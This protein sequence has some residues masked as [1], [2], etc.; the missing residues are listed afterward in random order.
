MGLFKYIND[1]RSEMKHVAWPTHRQTAVFTILVIVLSLITAMYL[2]FFDFLFTR[3]LQSV[4]GLET[5]QTATTTDSGNELNLP[6]G[7][8]FSAQAVDENGVPVDITTETN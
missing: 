1:T 2:G 7:L 3:A 6:E 5:Q 4:V 8:D